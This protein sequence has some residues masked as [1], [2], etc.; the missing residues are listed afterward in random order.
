MMIENLYQKPQ[1]KLSFQC[2][3]SVFQYFM[4]DFTIHYSLFIIYNLLFIILFLDDNNEDS[5]WFC[6]QCECIDDCLDLVNEQCETEIWLWTDLFPEISNI[7]KK[8]L[9]VDGML[10]LP[11]HFILI[12][13]MLFYYY[14]TFILLLFYY[15]FHS[16]IYFISFFRTTL[17]FFFFSLINFSS[18]SI[19]YQCFLC[20]IFVWMKLQCN[21]IISVY[22]LSY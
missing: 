21:L 17:M 22:N 4:F 10:S 16:L 9:F 18:H 7:S 1:Q 19:F 15:Y 20:V 6:W 2:F 8:N 12:N 3:F 5:D 13:I 11:C 14:F